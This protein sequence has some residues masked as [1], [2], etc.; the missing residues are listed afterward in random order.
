MRKV[1]RHT[2]KFF[3]LLIGV[4]IIVIGALMLVLPG[5]GIVVIIFGLV[6]LAS[7]FAWAKSTL[8]KAKGHY[9][10]TKNKITKKKSA[11]QNQLQE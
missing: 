6:V 8:D 3:V 11:D 7:E 1:L 5:P 2:K 10:S 9:E 4:T